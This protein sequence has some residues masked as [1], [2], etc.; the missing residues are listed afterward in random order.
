M[1]TAAVNVTG[2]VSLTIG[3]VEELAGETVRL[4]D[5]QGV[6]DPPLVT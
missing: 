1:G 4:T 6:G 5:V 3:F 2:L